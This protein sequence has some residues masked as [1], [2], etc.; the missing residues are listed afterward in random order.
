MIHFLMLKG[1]DNYAICFK[2]LAEQKEK[3]EPADK[4]QDQEKASDK[5][6]KAAERTFKPY[7]F[8]KDCVCSGALQNRQNRWRKPIL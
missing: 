3:E 6:L 5:K 4:S 1:H 7:Y 2:N 8:S